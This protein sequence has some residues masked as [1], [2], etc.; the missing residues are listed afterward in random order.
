MHMAYEYLSR[1][2]QDRWLVTRFIILLCDIR[3][4]ASSHLTCTR[5]SKAAV[6]SAVPA[7]MGPMINPQ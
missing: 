1:F 5:V 6:T 7:D 4:Q 2:S 3:L